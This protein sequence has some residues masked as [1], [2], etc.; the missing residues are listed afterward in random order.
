[1]N[2]VLV[3]GSIEW[4]GNAGW[5]P[6]SVCVDWLSSNFAI[7]CNVTSSST[8]GDLAWQLEDCQPQLPNIRCSQLA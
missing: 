4:E 1:M 7:L 3:G 8:S 6:E 2:A 5:E